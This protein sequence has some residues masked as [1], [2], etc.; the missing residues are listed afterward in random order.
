[1]ISLLVMVTPVRLGNCFSRDGQSMDDT[2]LRSGGC[3]Q[4]CVMLLD[5][6]P[7]IYRHCV[8]L[9]LG[10]MEQLNLLNG[11]VVLVMSG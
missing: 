9:S 6:T 4:S 2:E 8:N 3:A 7:L 11:M 10:T 1:M 5:H